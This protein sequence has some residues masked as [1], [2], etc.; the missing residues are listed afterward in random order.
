MGLSLQHLLWRADDGEDIVTCQRVVGLCGGGT[1][2]C[3]L[4][5]STNSENETSAQARWRH[6]SGVRECH[7]CLRGCQETSRHFVRHNSGRSA[8]GSSPRNRQWNNAMTIARILLTQLNNI[9]TVFGVSMQK[10][11]PEGPRRYRVSFSIG[12]SMSE[13]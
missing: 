13:S 6:T 8:Y 12:S 4:P 1:R 3:N 2:V 5:L 11:Y 7:M 9:A 10:R